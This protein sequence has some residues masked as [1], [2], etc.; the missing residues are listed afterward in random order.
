MR[1]SRLWLAATMI[2]AAIQMAQAGPGEQKVMAQARADCASFENGKLATTRM[3]NPRI[4]VTGDGVLNTI[5]DSRQFK[6]S[7]SASLYCGTGGCSIWV[8]VD[9]K[10]HSF[11]AKAWEV[12]QMNGKPVL[13][14]AV[15]GSECGGTNLRRCVRAEVWSEGAFHSV[16]DK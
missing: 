4:D 3:A 15:H 11:L 10:P 5:I 7:S 6:C 2:L 12:A 8:I 13:L 16:A 9:E 14:L 1:L